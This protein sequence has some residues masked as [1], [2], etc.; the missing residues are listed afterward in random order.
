LPQ[1]DGLRA[2]AVSMVV[3]AHIGFLLHMPFGTRKAL[4]P[5]IEAD[6]VELFFVLSGYLITTIL[7]RERGRSGRMSLRAFYLR[8]VLRIAPAFYAFLIAV[9]ILAATGHAAV[10]PLALLASAAYLWDYSPHVVPWIQHTWSLA[11]EEQFYLLWPLLL[12]RSRPRVAAAACIGGMVLAPVL[13]WTTYGAI[14]SINPGNPAHARA[15]ALL[16]GCLLALLPVLKSRRVDR[17]LAIVRRLHLDQLGGVLYLVAIPYV[18]SPYIFTTI[19]GRVRFTFGLSFEAVLGALLVLALVSRERWV[20]SRVLARAPLRP[21]G[22]ISYS[23]YLWQEPFLLPTTHLPMAGRVAGILATATASHWLIERPFLRLKRRFERGGHQ[24]PESRRRLQLPARL[25]DR[26]A[27]ATALL[28]VGAAL[29]R[30]D[31]VIVTRHSYRLSGDAI[32]YQRL[33]LSLLHGHGFGVSHFAAAGGPTALRPPGFPIWLAGVEGVT[34]GHVLAARLA[35]AIVGAAVVPLIVILARR[36]GGSRV[37]SL[38]AGVVVAVLPQMLLVSQSL[39]SEAVFV[40]L[41]LAAVVAAM[42]F[43]HNGRGRWLVAAGVALGLAVIT[44]PAGVVLCLPVLLLVATRARQ[45]RRYLPAAGLAVALAA[46]PAVVWEARTM[47]DLHAAVPLTTQGGYLL[48]GTYNAT[49]AAQ[50]QQ[51]GVWLPASFDP[52]DASVLALHPTATEAQT[53]TLLQTAA[54][55]YVRDHPGYLV[56]VAAHNSLRLADLTDPSFVRAVNRNE[57]GIGGA[58]DSAEQVTTLLLLVAAACGIARGALRRWPVA[59]WLAPLLLVLV[60]IPVQSFT[61]FRAPADPYLVLLA[62]GVGVVARGRRERQQ[63]AASV[64]PVAP[65][66]PLASSQRQPLDALT[67]L[68]FVAALVV[69]L[70]HCALLLSPWLPHVQQYARIVYA[71]PTGVGFFFML[72]GFVLTWSRR[73]GDTTGAFYRRRIARI[74]P[75]Y[76][77]CWLL[78]LAMYAALSVHVTTGPVVTSALLVQAWVPLQRFFGTMDTPG[79]SL[80]VEAFFYLLFPM[81]I[82]RLSRLRRRGVAAV[83]CVVV[84]VPVLAVVLTPP[85]MSHLPTTSRQWLVVD[86]PPVR[87]ADFVL[88]ITVALAVG[89]GRLRWLRPSRAAMAC[90]VGFAAVDVVHDARVMVVITLVPFAALLASVAHAEM[91]GGLR[92]LRRPTV[93]RLGQWSFAL[94]LVHWPLLIVAEHLHPYAFGSTVSAYTGL[95]VV[96]LI[97]VGISGL[98]FTLVERPLERRLRPRRDVPIALRED[99]GLTGRPFASA[100]ALAARHPSALLPGDV[101]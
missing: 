25:R 14:S 21:L 81:L 60:T 29:L 52:H 62:V 66:G 87:L 96:V 19:P 68:R 92:W 38:V 30:V 41:S 17:T 80:A 12:T 8:R 59:V 73:A 35:D 13:R 99:A 44:R 34:G 47:H 91:A 71:G 6:G 75:L 69:V 55:D 88:G 7:V 48:A 57:F 74:V 43:R 67:S 10:S 49:S 1:L 51:P 11:V 33:A 83:A 42:E 76:L 32:D 4:S 85:L 90:V 50:S 78:T 86:A 82:V 70:L 9:A 58:L 31:V 100:P 95:V 28:T 94:Y 101:A 72:S 39:M 24:S 98:L 37:V 16:V 20:L 93:V 63:L 54:V 53:S 61:R 65:A 79:W 56:T 36:L 3:L 97:A 84:L 89:S 45:W 26:F 23:V 46:A 18:L 2:I 77:V 15:D 5:V 40:P 22:V 64:A 27:L